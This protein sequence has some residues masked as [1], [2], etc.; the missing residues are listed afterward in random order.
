M[1]LRVVR[2]GQLVI[3]PDRVSAVR[4]SP[5]SN[6]RVHMWELLIDGDWRNT[7]V[8]CCNAHEEHVLLALGW[9]SRPTCDHQL[10]VKPPK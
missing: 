10:A 2:I 8:L 6:G 9:E 4:Q 7:G 1:S 5:D 3:R